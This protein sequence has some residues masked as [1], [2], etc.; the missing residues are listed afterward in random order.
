MATPLDL[1]A[2]AQPLSCEHRIEDMALVS[3]VQITGDITL[4]SPLTHSYS[5]ANSFVS[6]ALI[7]GDMQARV[8]KFFSQYTWTSIWSDSLVRAD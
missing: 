3:D 4:V 2:Y 7:I 6:S 1:S 8:S 5:A